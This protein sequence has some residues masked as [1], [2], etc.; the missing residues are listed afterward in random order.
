LP[1]PDKKRAGK[2]REIACTRQKKAGASPPW[3]T[4]SPNGT[5]GGKGAGRGK[6]GGKHFIT[7]LAKK[8]PR[9]SARGGTPPAVVSCEE[10]KISAW[11]KGR[12]GAKPVH[13]RQKKTHFS[14]FLG[15]SAQHRETPRGD[16]TKREKKFVRGVP[17]KKKKG[18]R[19]RRR[20]RKGRR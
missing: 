20:T 5:C 18:G 1:P 17:R 19:S 7:A 12:K 6:G 11:K 3:G 8:A 16:S 10:K 13:R 15:R 9:S 4:G 14:R 2:R